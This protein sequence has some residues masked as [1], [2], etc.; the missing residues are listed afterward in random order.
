MF[1]RY[2]LNN[3][4]DSYEYVLESE[5]ARTRARQARKV[6]LAELLRGSASAAKPQ[7]VMISGALAIATASFLGVMLTSAP[8]RLGRVT[9]PVCAERREPLKLSSRRPPRCRERRRT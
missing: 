6:R 8:V 7:V 5:A 1:N 2:D 3:S 4:L 9:G